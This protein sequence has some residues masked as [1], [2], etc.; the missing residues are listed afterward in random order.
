LPN[1]ERES[2][3]T[4]SGNGHVAGD[5]IA[6]R[7]SMPCERMMRLTEISPPRLAGQATN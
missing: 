3:N 2:A 7:I 6:S 1:I 5:L 4:A